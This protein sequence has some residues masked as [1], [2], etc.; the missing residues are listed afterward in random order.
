MSNRK[1]LDG[2]AFG[3]LVAEGGTG[4]FESSVG[5]HGEQNGDRLRERMPGR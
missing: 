4:F 1:T 5:G 2:S 3:A